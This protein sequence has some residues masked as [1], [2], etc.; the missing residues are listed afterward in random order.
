MPNK[1]ITISRAIFDKLLDRIRDDDP[2][3]TSLKLGRCRIRERGLD[4]LEK[5]Y[6][7]LGDD[8]TCEIANAL[9]S[10]THLKRLELDHNNI[11]SIGASALAQRQ[12]KSLD[13][14]SNKVRRN[15]AKSLAQNNYLESLSLYNNP[16]GEDGAKAFLENT[17]LCNLDIYFK[18]I[19]QKTKNDVRNH[20]AENADRITGTTTAS[21]FRATM[22]TSLRSM[23]HSKPVNIR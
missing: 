20:I 1:V 17:T 11:T 15:G 22:A 23:T 5:G 4:N 3:L 6:G 7:N 18:E 14:W 12:L 2:T 19:E 16:I 13:L 9:V 10:N 21:V 8:E